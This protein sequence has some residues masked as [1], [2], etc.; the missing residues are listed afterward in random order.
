V[1][2]IFQAERTKPVYERAVAFVTDHLE[3]DA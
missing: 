2:D 1:L 3:L